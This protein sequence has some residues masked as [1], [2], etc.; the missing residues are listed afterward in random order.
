M[1]PWWAEETC[2][3]VCV[4]CSLIQNFLCFFSVFFFPFYS[5]LQAAEQLRK[6]GE[7][8]YKMKKTEVDGGMEN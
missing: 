3:N 4:N 2:C 8:H 1:Q 5:L 7:E 6:L